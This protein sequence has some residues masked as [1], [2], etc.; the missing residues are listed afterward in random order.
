MKCIIY[1]CSM[2]GFKI[3]VQSLIKLPLLQP[4]WWQRHW[5]LLPAFG[6]LGM[7]LPG[8]WFCCRSF[9]IWSLRNGAS[10]GHF[11]FPNGGDKPT[12]P[13]QR[14]AQPGLKFWPTRPDA[15]NHSEFYDVLRSQLNHLFWCCRVASLSKVCTRT[16]QEPMLGSSMPSSL[17]FGFQEDRGEEAITALRILSELQVIN[18]LKLSKSIYLF[19]F[20]FQTLLL[21]LSPSF[22]WLLC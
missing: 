10:G 9:S 18:S 2:K 19:H 6:L 5:V 21:A 3:S 15:L 7:Q 11:V 1:I 4:R 22:F 20:I 14:E 17:P 13:L 8:Q 12:G 16:H